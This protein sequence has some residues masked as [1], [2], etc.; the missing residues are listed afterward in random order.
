MTIIRMAYSQCLLET[1]LA[2]TKPST[3]TAFPLQLRLHFKPA[4]VG[5]VKL[6]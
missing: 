3:A 4:R 5:G 6:P 2:L 1:M